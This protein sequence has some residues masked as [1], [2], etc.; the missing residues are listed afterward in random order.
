MTKQQCDGYLDEIQ[1]RMDG[2]LFKAMLEM[3]AQ[4]LMEE[5]LALHLRAERHERT[6][7]RRGHRNGY[8]ARRLKTRVGELS[9]QVPQARGVEPYSPMLFAK[10]QRAVFADAV[11]QVAAQRTGAV[12]GVRGDVFHGGVHTQGE[13]GAGEDG[14]V[15]AVG[16]DGVVRGQ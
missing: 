3:I 6:A 8:K 14:R 16:V 5:E 4:R 9:L 10:W 11:R 1:E 7:E 13:T 2:D 15:R 12:G